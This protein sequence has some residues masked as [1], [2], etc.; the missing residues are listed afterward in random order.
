MGYIRKPVKKVKFK[1]NNEEKDGVAVVKVDNRD[2]NLLSNFVK[3]REVF[4][5]LE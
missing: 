3:N 1:G 4:R 2:D 5:R